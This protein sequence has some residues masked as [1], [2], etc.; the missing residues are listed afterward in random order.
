MFEWVIPAACQ[1]LKYR[2]LPFCSVGTSSQGLLRVFLCDFPPRK[3]INNSP[4]SPGAALWAESGWSPQNYCRFLKVGQPN[5]SHHSFS[6]QWPKMFHHHSHTNDTNDT[7]TNT[8]PNNTNDCRF[9]KVGQPSPSQIFNAVMAENVSPFTST[10]DWQ[11]NSPLNI[12]TICHTSYLS[13]PSQSLV[14]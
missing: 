4:P 11:I 1:T 7:N 6:I 12:Q 9:L 14:V 13:Q 2:S 10:F 3:S 5:L 8:K